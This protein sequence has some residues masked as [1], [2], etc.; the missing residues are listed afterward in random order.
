MRYHSSLLILLLSLTLISQSIFARERTSTSLANKL[1]N[2]DIVFQ[3]IPCGDLCIAIAE[4]TPCARERPFN[5]CG[6]IVKA[7][8]SVSVL[9]A[10]GKD[11]HTTPLKVFMKRDTALQLYVGRPLKSSGVDPNAADTRNMKYS[12]RLPGVRSCLVNV[13]G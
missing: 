2:G 13:A 10:I 6:I 12:M 7:G 11:V 1:R 3:Y 9:E 8:D 5:H 4:T